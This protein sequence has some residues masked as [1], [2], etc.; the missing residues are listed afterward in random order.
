M[1]NCVVQLHL[2]QPHAGWRNGSLRVYRTDLETGQALAVALERDQLL[3]YLW[4]KMLAVILSYQDVSV[5]I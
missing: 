1:A 5:F 3:V 4:N 2:H